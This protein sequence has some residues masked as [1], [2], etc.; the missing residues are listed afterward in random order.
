MP[1]RVISGIV[2]AVDPPLPILI[3]SGGWPSA[4]IS[5]LALGLP[6]KAAY[7]PSRFHQYFKPSKHQ[8]MAWSSPLDF[9]STTN[10]GKVC[11]VI[12][13]TVKFL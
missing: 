3:I 8:I 5:V 12:S 13:G 10:L 7:F 2:R 9:T 4:L 11:F 1:S 6:L